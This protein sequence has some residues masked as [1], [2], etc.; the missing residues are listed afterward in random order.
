L[1]YKFLPA[2]D[3]RQRIFA[4]SQAPGQDHSEQFEQTIDGIGKSLKDLKPRVFAAHSVKG[5]RK[6]IAAIVADISRM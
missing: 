2:P 6:A 1:S 5:V 4:L 3:Q